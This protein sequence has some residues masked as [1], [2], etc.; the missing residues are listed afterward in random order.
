MPISLNFSEVEKLEFP[1]VVKIAFIIWVLSL[2][3]IDTQYL[4]S[5]NFNQTFKEIKVLAEIV[6][7]LVAY[8]YVQKIGKF[9]KIQNLD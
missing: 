4:L 2:N 3:L 6:V 7:C 5:V 8:Q 9:Q 1:K